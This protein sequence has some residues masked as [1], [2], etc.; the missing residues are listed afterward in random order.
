MLWRAVKSVVRWRPAVEMER[1]VQ[2][3]GVVGVVFARQRRRRSTY[4][5]AKG[6]RPSPDR[7]MKSIF[8]L[9]S[10][11]VFRKSGFEI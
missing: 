6:A 9:I 5:A 2:V 1:K 10:I 3:G 4:A 7:S 8:E 11:V